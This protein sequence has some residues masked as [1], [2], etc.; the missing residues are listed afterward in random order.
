MAQCGEPER[1]HGERREQDAALCLAELTG[2]QGDDS[3]HPRQQERH[4]HDDD[5]RA[6]QAPDG[7]RGV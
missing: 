1:R 3:E 2:E 5:R 7:G 4:D 6:S